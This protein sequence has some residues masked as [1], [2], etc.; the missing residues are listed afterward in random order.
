METI[1]IRSPATK[2]GAVLLIGSTFFL[3]VLILIC[4]LFVEQVT[5]GLGLLFIVSLLG[6]FA[7]WA[8]LAEPLYCLICDEAGIHYC[9]R[10]G[11][12]L[13]P[14]QGFL[15]SAVPQFDGRNLGYIG[16]KVTDY[17]A[18]LATLPL[19]LAVRI[20]TEQRF[21]FI[22]AVRQSCA[23]G[24]CASELL[25]EGDKFQTKTQRYTGIKA[26]FAQRMQRL[27]AATGYDI[28]VP[29]A[30]DEEQGKRLCQLINQTRLQLIQNTAT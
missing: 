13:L 21:L 24:Q 30:F 20:M 16:F 12:W 29:V 25:A 28:F 27:A 8:K 6:M 22:E 7:G 23:S 1:Q 11:R 2:G 15:Y 4:G 3:L 9:H 5:T 19:R 18:F 26:I 17:D 14:W 10:Y